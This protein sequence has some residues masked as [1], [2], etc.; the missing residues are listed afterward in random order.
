[1]APQILDLRDGGYFQLVAGA[2]RL[3]AA[4]SL[5]WE[6]IECHVYVNMSD[7]EAEALEIVENLERKDLTAAE[8]KKW[9]KA[10]AAAFERMDDA[11]KPRQDV[12][13]SAKGGRGKKGVASKVAEATGLTSRRVNQIL[14]EDK[15]PKGSSS[16][17]RLHR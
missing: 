12:A 6:T 10:L 14:A 2:R 11:A 8:R 9:V 15:K 5:G 7:D 16:L 1:M 3:E 13:V 4:K 17:E